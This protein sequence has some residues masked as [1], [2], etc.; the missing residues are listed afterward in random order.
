MDRNSAWATMQVQGDLL[1][2]SMFWNPPKEEQHKW[3]FKRP[4]KP[5]REQAVR[6]YESH[7]GM[8]QEGGR[9]SSYREY[10][11]HILPRVKKAG[12]NSIQ[13]MAI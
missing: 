11:E 3:E 8:A 2:D 9:V 10:A 1:F 13:L 12:Y 6:I 7:V 4:V 5:V